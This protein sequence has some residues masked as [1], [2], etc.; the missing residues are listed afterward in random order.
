MD[1]ERLAARHVAVWL[2]HNCYLYLMIYR[3][4]PPHTAVDVA[5]IGLLTMLNPMWWAGLVICLIVGLAI[6][7]SWSGP[8]GVWI[9]LV[10]T[11][12]IPG[13]ALAV[14][15]ALITK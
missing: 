14:F 10:A 13:G 4:L 12:L 6:A 15:L 3:H 8:L 11:G 7:R 5:S 9:A 2:W 1:S